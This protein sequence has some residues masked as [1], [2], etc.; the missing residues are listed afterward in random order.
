MNAE[1]GMT[2]P[3]DRRD[4]VADRLLAIGVE[5]LTKL[6]RS[7]RPLR[8]ALQNIQQLGDDQAARRAQ[9]LTRQLDAIEPSVTMI[10]QIKS[11]KTSLVNAMVGWPGLLP[12][13]VNPWTSVVTSLHVSPTQK[14]PEARAKFKFFDQTE[15][16]RLVRG[17]GRIG[18]LANRAG[19]E[20]ELE[21]IKQQI[22]EMREKS[23]ARLGR[24]FEMLLGQEHSYGEFDEE[25]IERYV[26][27]GD[28]YD[29]DD[30]D[31]PTSQGR[32][33]DITKSADLF[34]HRKA[35]PM[36]LCVRDTPGVNDTFM[37]REQITI[38]AIR[39]SRLCVVVLSAH[40]ALSSTDL[41]LIR[42]ISNI[43]SREVII[44]VNRIDELSDPRTQVP[45]IRAS[46]L[47][48]LRQHKGPVDAHILF[49][50]A[51][52]ANFAMSGALSKLPQA[53]A[54][55]LYNWAEGGNHSIG[56]DSDPIELLWDLSG[57]PSLYRAISDRVS[58]GVV[59]DTV[60]RIAASALNLVNGVAAAQTLIA[61]PQRAVLKVSPE[62]L[63]ANIARIEEAVSAN[64]AQDYDVIIAEFSARVDRA[65]NTFLERATASLIMHLEHY[66]EHSVWQYDP[67]GLR[68]LLNS[69]YRALGSQCQKA[70]TRHCEAA[71][72]EFSAL[73][74]SAL[75][76]SDGTLQ[77]RVPPPARIPPPVTL[78][79]TIALD[80]KGNWWKSW[81]FR[82][83]GYQAYA[84]S[85]HDLIRAETEV[86]V[87]DL[88]DDHARSIRQTCDA[89]IGAFLG[90]QRA[91]LQ[92]LAST[93]TTDPDKVDD[94]LGLGRSRARAAVLEKTQTL[95]TGFLS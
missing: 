32:F 23:M 10:G 11:G 71:A 49:G 78:G 36:P 94:L 81:W 30:E 45:E 59:P 38:Q 6:A 72:A 57:L 18:E 67:A 68:V 61:D 34:V 80:L 46:I 82:R 9:H 51:L 83:R 73:A 5:D 4:P 3:L 92:G 62:A 69:S 53:S 58:E 40:Q 84:A 37:M 90:E 12:A 41:A 75:G 47:D 89:Q 55:A 33:A 28:E 43:K 22:T 74:Q 24:K 39:D 29:E 76:L 66:G 2:A 14:T 27:L 1:T 52:W 65:L 44:F 50:S 91:I 56:A 26:C 54:A 8:G 85:F 64:A 88:K 35:I 16:D 95:L 79:R 7:L 13:D 19:A 87:T 31:I 20:D 42:L 77:I 17:G 86:F 48:T 25:L 60:G 63:E 15:W 70:F 21:T 93:N